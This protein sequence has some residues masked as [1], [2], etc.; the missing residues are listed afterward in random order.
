M[1]IYLIALLATIV[2]EFVCFLVLLRREPLKLLL[3]SVLI[4]SFTQPLATYFFQNIWGN[5][6][7]TEILVTLVE[8]L[9]IKLLLKTSYG[10]A[11]F[12]S[13]VANLVTSIISLLFF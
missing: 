6:Y 3:F 5:F 2:I 13:L 11:L 9:L 4:N 7:T 10:K 12:I 1:H 8:S